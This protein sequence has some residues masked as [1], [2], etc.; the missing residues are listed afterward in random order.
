MTLFRN[1]FVKKCTWCGAGLKDVEPVERMGKRFCG[2]DHA[3]E[4]LE[5][6]KS[7]QQNDSGGCC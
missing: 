2:K 1:L 4:Y 6:A 7:V 3:I 5:H